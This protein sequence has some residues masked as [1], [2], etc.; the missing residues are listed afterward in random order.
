MST[1]L[2]AIASKLNINTL[3]PLRILCY[4]WYPVHYLTRFKK[5]H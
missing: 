5:D 4:Y 3:T 1:V 2:K